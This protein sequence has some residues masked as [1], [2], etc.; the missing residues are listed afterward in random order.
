MFREASLILVGSL[1]Q[2]A[3]AALFLVGVVMYGKEKRDRE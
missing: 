3:A 1:S 2:M